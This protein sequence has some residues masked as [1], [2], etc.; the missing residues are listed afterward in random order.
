MS[1]QHKLR[2]C[3]SRNHRGRPCDNPANQNGYCNAHN[4][5]RDRFDDDDNDLDPG[6]TEEDELDKLAR[7][8]DEFEKENGTVDT[9]AER[10]SEPA[11]EPLKPLSFN[12]KIS[13]KPTTKPT[14]S[15]TAAAII[16]GDLADSLPEIRMVPVDDLLVDEAYQ[17]EMSGKKIK[18][19]IKTGFNPLAAG[20]LI[21]NRRPDGSLFIIDGRHRREAAKRSGVAQILC[22]IWSCSPANESVAFVLCNAVR[23]PPTPLELFKARLSSSESKAIEI[24]SIVIEL[25]LK[26]AFR[27][28]GESMTG[29][30]SSIHCISAVEK[31]Y[32]KIGS[33][34]LKKVLRT[35][36]DLW[37]DDL[38]P[39]SS[40]PISGLTLFF[41]KYPEITTD[42][43]TQRLSDT[44]LKSLITKARQLVE[45]MR[46]RVTVAFARTVI[47]HYNRGLKNRLLSSE[48]LLMKSAD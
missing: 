44:A 6:A 10:I 14:T 32:D 19:I 29:Y 17:R 9:P 43:L 18:E 38:N 13:R 30:R 31:S 11:A 40:V 41:Q 46:G 7:E 8:I 36:R 21:V 26:L 5:K 24:N 22:A 47:D 1:A 37:S 28:P 2:N 15:T 25:N 39:F 48:R 4:P 20:T 33:D 12:E 34:G 27:S 3:K 35:I 16:Q 42:I 23:Q 45:T